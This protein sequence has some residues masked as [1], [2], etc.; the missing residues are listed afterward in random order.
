MVASIDYLRRHSRNAT[1]EFVSP[2]F[3]QTKQSYQFR[4]GITATAIAGDYLAIVV[5]R[6]LLFYGLNAALVAGWH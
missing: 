6:D 1:T 4:S 2:F 3:Q 5:G